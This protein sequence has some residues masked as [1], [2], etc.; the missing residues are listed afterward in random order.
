MTFGR[1]FVFVIL[2]WVFIRTIS[3]GKWTWDKKNK[4]GAVMIYIVALAAI[5]LPIY[6]IYL[7]D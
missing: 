4:L 5:V 2:L 6:T 7:R 3:Y 1:F